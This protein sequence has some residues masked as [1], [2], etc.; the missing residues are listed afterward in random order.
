MR[1]CR[2]AQVS[3]WSK[4]LWILG[5]SCSMFVGSTCRT[6]CCRY[7]MIHF[8][9]EYTTICGINGQAG[10]SCLP[11]RA[12]TKNT[13]RAFL[14]HGLTERMVADAL[15]WKCFERGLAARRVLQSTGENVIVRP[16]SDLSRALL[17]VRTHGCERAR[18]GSVLQKT[19]DVG[20]RMSES[21][22]FRAQAT[23]RTPV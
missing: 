10:I 14:R 7:L 19:S 6:T 11:S 22:C 23:P 3:L 5:P 12:K 16:W 9:A 8:C 21:W 20:Q 18:P 1:A 4:T 15:H 17:R 13:M 2:G